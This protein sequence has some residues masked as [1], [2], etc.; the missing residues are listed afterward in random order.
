MGRPIH[1][2]PVQFS[3][4]GIEAPVQAQIH[5]VD[6]IVYLSGEV[7][8]H[9]ISQVIAGMISL[10]NHDPKQPITLVIST[11]GGSVDEMFSLYDTIKYLPCPVQTVGIGK[12]MSAGVLLLASGQKGKRLIGEN[13]RVMI[14]PISATAGGNVFQILAETKEYVRQQ[15]QMEKLLLR[16]TKM[17]EK[18]L[19]KFMKAG[20]DFY[21]MPGEAVRLGIADQVIGN[22]EK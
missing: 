5:S 10:A 4:E 19:Q 9:L 15:E 18:D 13:S 20:Y 14:H 8:E 6:R 16:E 11:Y 17:S 7:T 21:M 22:N 1:S 3:D 12:V 2:R